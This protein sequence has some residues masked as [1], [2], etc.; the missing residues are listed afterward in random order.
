[1]YRIGSNSF[2]PGRTSSAAP[3]APAKKRH[4][5]ISARRIDSSPLAM[6]N[7]PRRKRIYKARM[8]KI[9][10]A[11]ALLLSLPALS[12]EVAGV[13]VP[14]TMTVEGKE[15]KLNGAGIRKKLVFKVYVGALYLEAP[16]TDARAIVTSDQIKSVHMTFMRNVEKDKILNA[17]KEGFENNTPGK[18]A[19]LSKE[20]DRIGPDL[21]DLK[22]GS[23][24]IVTYVP[25]KGT[26]IAIKGG[27]E[28][29]VAGKDFGD[30]IFRNWLGANPADDDLKKEMLAGK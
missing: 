25:G 9:A 17:F 14:E 16:S 21:K 3:A 19:A 8:K 13:K 5:P 18:A 2:S 1:L 24:M 12:K 22:E 29:S 27:A 10:C 20:I 23:E 6:S 4:N 26:T 30:A 11:A 28:A 15:L 7:V